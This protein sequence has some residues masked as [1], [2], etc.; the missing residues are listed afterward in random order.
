MASN[1]TS[2]N[3]VLIIWCFCLERAGEGQWKSCQCW[4]TNGKPTCALCADILGLI[5]IKLFLD[6]SLCR[7]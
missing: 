4:N 6:Q 5:G 3:W 7:D 1:L 2:I